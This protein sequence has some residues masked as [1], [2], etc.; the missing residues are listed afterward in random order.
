[1][2]D[3]DCWDDATPQGLAPA[4]L[5]RLEEFSVLH[6]KKLDSHM[7]LKHR[8]VIASSIEQAIGE[9]RGA[10]RIRAYHCS[11]A[12]R[13][14]VPSYQVLC[15]HYEVYNGGLPQRTALAIPGVGYLAAPQRK[16]VVF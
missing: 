3:K 16:I 11:C 2:K 15:I 8:S 12:G 13:E 14:A 10:D 5:P 6:Q 9:L 7:P 4:P 1:V